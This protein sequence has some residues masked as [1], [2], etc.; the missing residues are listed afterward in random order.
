MSGSIPGVN[1]KVGRCIIVLF[2]NFFCS[3][4]ERHF[5]ADLITKLL[6]QG[7]GGGYVCVV[8]DP[9]LSMEVVLKIIPLGPAGSM[10]RLSHEKMIKKE[11]EIGLIIAKKSRYL[12]LYTETFHWV[13]YFCIKMEYCRLGDLQ[14]QFDSGRV[15]TEEA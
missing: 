12:V 1:T 11:M 14:Y 7:G 4:Y 2:F 13:D 9:D 10:E 5:F 6:K 8:N 3:I 15:F